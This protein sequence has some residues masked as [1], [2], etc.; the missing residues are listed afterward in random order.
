LEALQAQTLTGYI[1]KAFAMLTIIIGVAS[2]LV[3]ST[4]R[5]RLEIGIIRAMG[6]GRWFVMVV[7]VAQRALIG[8]LD[9]GRAVAAGYYPRRPWAG[10][11]ADHLGRDCRL[12]PAASILPA[13]A[14]ARLDPVTAIGQ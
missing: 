3:L 8:L 2:A 12:D 10:D 5:R 1:L 7:F 11:R 13:R 4:Y 6:A 14:A 9:R